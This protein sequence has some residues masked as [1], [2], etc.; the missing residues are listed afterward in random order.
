MSQVTLLAHT[1]RDR[2]LRSLFVIPPRP[3]RASVSPG[4]L[5]SCSSP[6]DICPPDLPVPSAPRTLAP[7]NA[8]GERGGPREN[9]LDP[10]RHHRSAPSLHFRSAAAMLLK[11]LSWLV[12]CEKSIRMP[13]ADATVYRQRVKW[14]SGRRC[15]RHP[16]ANI[17]DGLFAPYWAVSPAS[18][19]Q[20]PLREAGAIL[21]RANIGRAELRRQRADERQ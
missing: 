14:K 9:P 7:P 10:R 1:S 6:F 20:V 21:S 3:L 13:E 19:Q 11:S 17:M 4:L 2:A 18:K 8:A 5:F 16:P 15:L 12:W